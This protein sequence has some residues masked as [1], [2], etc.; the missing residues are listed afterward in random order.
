[1]SYPGIL[2]R[3]EFATG[4]ITRSIKINGYYLLVDNCDVNQTQSIDTANDFL[5][6]GPANAVARY[7]AKKISGSISFPVRIDNDGNL[8]QAVIE[9]INHAQYPISP[10]EM[11]TNH[12]LLHRYLTAENHATDDNELLKIDNLLVQSLTLSCSQNET[13]N[14]SINFEGMID[15]F[16]NSDFTIPDENNLLGRALTWGDCNAFREESSMRQITSFSITINNEIET[17]VFLSAYNCP[18]TGL[19]PGRTDQIGIMGI[20]SVKWGG[21]FTELVRS[22]SDLN[23]FIHGGLMLNENLTF[24]IGPMTVL[25]KNPLFEI[26]KLPLTSSVLTRTIKWNAITKPTEP[27]SEGK[28]F[29][30]N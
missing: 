7:D 18:N 20:K 1:M 11:D 22:G 9:L 14:L 19:S 30:F 17:P 21:Q 2:T 23:T 24:D 6:G 10:L 25:F 28:L 12:I 27:L 15:D 26:T 13:V 16:V 29:T 5:Q 8:D 4:L 3:A